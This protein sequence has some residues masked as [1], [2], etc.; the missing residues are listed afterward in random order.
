MPRGRREGFH[1][2]LSRCLKSTAAYAAGVWSGLTAWAA[3]AQYVLPGRG[4]AL[5][6]IGSFHWVLWI[7]LV[8]A[9]LCA[10]GFAAGWTVTRR[11]G[12]TAVIRGRTLLV[13]GLLFPLTALLLRPLFGLLSAG[14]TPALVWCVLGSAAVGAYARAGRP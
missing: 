6:K 12:P 10:L 8:P 14:T 9:L 3:L 13:L 2:R 7:N 1:V 11:P 5:G 4:D